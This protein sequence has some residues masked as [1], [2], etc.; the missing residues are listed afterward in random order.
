MLSAA[1]FRVRAKTGAPSSCSIELAG[2]VLEARLDLAQAADAGP[3]GDGELAAGL[4][5]QL[6]VASVSVTILSW[7]SASDL[8]WSPILASCSMASCSS[9]S[10]RVC[11]SSSW[12]SL[13]S[14]RASSSFLSA[15]S[16]WS[17]SRSCWALLIL[18]AALPARPAARRR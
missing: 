5:A 12:A 11:S 6:L 7:R 14:A 4:R 15:S 13:R 16:P 18:P 10:L 8:S 9:A 17:W 2:L 1:R 3:L